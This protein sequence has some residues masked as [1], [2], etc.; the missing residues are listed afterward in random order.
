MIPVEP[1]NFPEQIACGFDDLVLRL[2]TSSSRFVAA[3]VAGVLSSR[4]LATTS[5]TID[6]TSGIHIHF[7]IASR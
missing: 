5:G 2:H 6:A 7:R 3:S 1:D 4:A